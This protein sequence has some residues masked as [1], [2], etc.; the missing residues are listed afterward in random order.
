[1]KTSARIPLQST[2]APAVISAR[3]IHSTTIPAA[4]R[5]AQALQR[6]ADTSPH[7]AQLRSLQ[8][9][10]C[11]ARLKPVIPNSPPL[12]LLPDWLNGALG[13][14]GAALAGAAIVGSAPVWAGIGGAA[15]LAYGASDAYANRNERAKAKAREKRALDSTFERLHKR[16]AALLQRLREMPPNQR[17]GRAET[18]RDLDEITQTR[19][20]L[21]ARTI[22]G[23]HELWL[24]DS[25]RGTD[26]DTAQNLWS[27]ISTNG[28]NVKIDQND[29]EFRTNTLTDISKLLQSPHGR[30]MLGALNTGQIGGNV[31]N[32]DIAPT[33]G[34]TD[35]APKGRP[36]DGATGEGSTVSINYDEPSVNSMGVRDEPLYDPSYIKLGHELGHARHYLAGTAGTGGASASLAGDSTEE[37]LWTSEEEYNNITR[38]ENPLRTELGLGKRRYHKDYKNVIRLKKILPIVDELSTRYRNLN[39]E[40]PFIRSF[41]PELEKAERWLNP[42][43]EWAKYETKDLDSYILESRADMAGL[44]KRYRQYQKTN[45]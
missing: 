39:L 21:I 18:E 19:R 7:T 20:T 9:Q 1:M 28:G 26:R 33:R 45:I 30:G 2:L 4:E 17:K 25:V 36:S 24:P 10:A 43:G 40:A 15:A 27:S 8:Q 12:Q 22:A 32:I 41:P 42:T 38:E 23:G 31:R 5:Q 6:M 3:A 11:Q 29:P 44:V 37:I 14:G 13:I 16:E 35:N 34:E